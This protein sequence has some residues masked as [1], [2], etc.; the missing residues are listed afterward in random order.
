MGK[1]TML[2]VWVCGYI[3]TALLFHEAVRSALSA[4]GLFVLTFLHMS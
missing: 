4:V 2:Q 3:F 1:G